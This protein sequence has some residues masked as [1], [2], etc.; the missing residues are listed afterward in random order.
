MSVLSRE[1]ILSRVQTI[2]GENTD[3]DSLA[4]V[5]DITDTLTDMENRAN[6]GGED[7]KTKYE[8]NDAEWRRK[9]KERFFNGASKEEEEEEDEKEE[10]KKKT[11]EDLFE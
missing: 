6:G 8:Q 9:Y 3:D 7:W 5:E 1:E 4:F 10:I 2:I 11:F